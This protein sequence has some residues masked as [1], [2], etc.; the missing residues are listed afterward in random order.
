MRICTKC[1]KEKDESQFGKSSR[2]KDGLTYWCAD[3]RKK[4]T[5]YYQEHRERTLKTHA[6][7]RQTDKY[8]ATKQRY[9][10]SEKG[11]AAA[12]RWQEKAKE[13]GKAK[14]RQAVNHA[15]ENGKIPRAS[16]CKCAM[17]DGTCNGPIEYHHKSYSKKNWLNVVP[18]CRKHHLLL[19]GI[20][21][22]F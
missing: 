7:H 9:Y 13:S 6:K 22:H 8:K 5:D 2:S 19:H 16:E 12:K 10:Y 21:C 18:L 11:Q 17:N 4:A 14:A 20:D 1:K 15:V 3:C